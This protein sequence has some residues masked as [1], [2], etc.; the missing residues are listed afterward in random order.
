VHLAASDDYFLLMRVLTGQDGPTC[1]FWTL[2]SVMVA[3]QRY[4]RLTLIKRRQT[5]LRAAAD[6]RLRTLRP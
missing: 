1:Q 2:R 4:Y 3:C 5:E 6:C